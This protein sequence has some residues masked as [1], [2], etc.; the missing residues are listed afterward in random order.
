MTCIHLG[1]KYANFRI[2][3][4]AE[5]SGKNFQTFNSSNVTAMKSLGIFSRNL[6]KDFFLKIGILRAKVYKK[7]RQHRSL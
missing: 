4:F 5:I 3:I 6:R 1:T 7:S 2:K